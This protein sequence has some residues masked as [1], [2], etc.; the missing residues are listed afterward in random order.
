MMDPCGFGW[1]RWTTQ[2]TWRE[3]SKRSTSAA[4]ADPQ[5]SPDY[6]AELLDVRT[7]IAEATVLLA[8]DVDRLIATITATTH[9]SH[10]ANIARCGE[11][12]IRILG[13]LRAGVGDA[14]T[15]PDSSPPG[16]MPPGLSTN[17]CV[18]RQQDAP[19]LRLQGRHP[20][21]QWRRWGR[22]GHPGMLIGGASGVPHKQR[23]HG[24]HLQ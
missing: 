15:Q 5:R 12:E 21:A 18:A 3:S 22:D 24:A 16:H 1:R 23:A 7:R 14:L 8:E 11:L 13:V 10:L 20:G 4:G 17:W 2:T 9:P 6:V 19:G